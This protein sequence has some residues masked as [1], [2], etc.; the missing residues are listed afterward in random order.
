[1]ETVHLGDPE[2]VIEVK[3]NIHLNETQRKGLNHLLDE[4]FIVFAYE[5]G[6]M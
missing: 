2:C 4:Y 6:E 1:M 3:I 5:V